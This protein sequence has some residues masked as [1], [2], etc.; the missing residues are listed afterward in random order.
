MQNSEDFIYNNSFN[1]FTGVIEDINDPEEMGRYKVRCFGYHSENKQSIDTKDL[2]WAHVMMPI[3][4][5]SMTGIGQSATGLKQGSWVVGFFRDG[6][7]AQDPLIMGS[8]PSL[9]VNTS[10][11]ALG[12]NDPSGNYPRASYVEG[13]EVDTPRPARAD[14]STSQPYVSKE[15]TRQLDIE[16]AVPPRVTSISPDKDDTYYTRSVWQNH[17]LDDIILPIYPDNHVVETE[18]GHIFEV[19]DTPFYERISQYHTSGTYEEV[20]SNGDK[21]VTVVGDEYEVTFKSKNMY[22]KGSVNLTVDGNMKTLVKGN[23]H[24]EVEGD[25]TEYIKGTRTSKIGQNELIEIDQERSI[26]VAENN[27]TRIGGNELRDVLK[28]STT[29]IVGNCGEA[30][31][32]SLTTN[33]S[34]DTK[35]TSIGELTLAS[36]QNFT[37]VTASTMKLDTGSNLDIDAGEPITMNTPQNIVVKGANIFLN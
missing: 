25:K 26:N 5:A 34:E 11:P 17:E 10:N 3:T 6:S 19:D 21:T 24:L 28:D 37:C 12:F 2:P 8:I 13:G 20:V 15:D 22:V 31:T 9:S 27:T 1:W 35:L 14:Y 18:S 7:N 36:F 23:Y 29:N 30:I 4:S 16:T 33:V 32:G